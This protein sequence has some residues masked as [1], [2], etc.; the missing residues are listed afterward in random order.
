[1]II[2]IVNLKGGAGKTTIATNTT[3]AL[4][5]QWKVLLID[6]DTQRSASQWF[7]NRERETDSFSVVSIVEEKSLKKQIPVFRQQY[8]H[9]VIDGA[10]QT[11]LINAIN[12]FVADLVIIPVLPSPYD[13]WAT[14][15]LLKRIKTAQELQPEKK[16]WFLLNRINDQTALSRDAAEALASFELPIF[17]TKLHNRVIYADSAA[18]GLSV[19]ESANPK[20]RMEFEEFYREIE[21]LIRKEK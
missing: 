21:T 8:D 13:I 20:A 7:D 17:K 1:M 2:S 9:I 19:L 16:A 14:E 15:T 6:T 3:F 12:I 5:R 10:P 4:S 11:D 18:S